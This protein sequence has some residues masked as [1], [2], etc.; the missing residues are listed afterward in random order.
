MFWY[1]L[2]SSKA[3]IIAELTKDGDAGTKK[4]GDARAQINGSH[5]S[6][7]VFPACDGTGRC[8]S[9]VGVTPTYGVERFESNPAAFALRREYHECP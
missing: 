6:H 4:G 9:R 7:S 2:L 3:F 8:G 1:L 5:R